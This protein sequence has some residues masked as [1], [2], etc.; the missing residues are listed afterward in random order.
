[1][2]VAQE[3]AEICSCFGIFKIQRCVY[4]AYFRSDDLFKISKYIEMYWKLMFK[5]DRTPWKMHLS[6]LDLAD[7]CFRVF[8]SIGH[9][10]WMGGP[11]KQFWSKHMSSPN[12]VFFHFWWLCVGGGPQNKSCW[13]MLSFWNFWV[14]ATFFSVGGGE[15]KVAQNVLKHTLIWNFWDPMNFFEWK[16]LT[17]LYRQTDAIL[18][19]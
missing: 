2:K 5:T 14:A 18:T 6:P 17:E 15:I 4:L 12:M 10:R 8:T 9:L 3:C 16:N 19:R 11:K 1:M 7:R 13:N